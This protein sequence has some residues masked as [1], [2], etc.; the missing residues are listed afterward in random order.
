MRGKA[1]GRALQQNISASK[2]T[3]EIKQEDLF[4]PF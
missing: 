3:K 2:E 4:D 1:V